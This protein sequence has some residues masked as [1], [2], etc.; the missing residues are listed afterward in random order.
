MRQNG[1]PGVYLLQVRG[2]CGGVHSITCNSE[3]DSTNASRAP[4]TRTRR[5][6]ISKIPLTRRLVSTAG[7]DPE[8]NVRNPEPGGTSRKPGVSGSFSWWQLYERDLN[9]MKKSETF[10][11]KRVKRFQKTKIVDALPERGV[12]RK[13]SDWGTSLVEV[14]PPKLDL[15]P[16]IGN[17]NTDREAKFDEK[18]L[19]PYA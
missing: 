17:L 5:V 7:A 18:A 2:H 6:A 15:F 12:K 11:N 19:V 9:V 4:R 8:N 14:V 16:T 3:D 1:I 10:V 13:N